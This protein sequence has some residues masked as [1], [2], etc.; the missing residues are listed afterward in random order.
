MRIAE[1]SR[2][3]GVP[4]PTIKYY[5]REG[6]LPAGELTSPNQARYGEEHVR[7][8]RLVRALLELGRL[9]I[10]TI[11][12][13]L[14]EVEGP[15]PD[16][17]NVLGRALVRPPAATTAEDPELAAASR[18]R[19]DDLIASR[20]WLVD[21]AAPAR[22]TV[23]DVLVAFQQLGSP[24][25]EF[26]LE[27]YAEAAERI[28]VTDL[29]FV[30]RRETPAELLHSAVIGTVLGESLL[31]ALRRLA[32]EHESAKTFRGQGELSVGNPNPPDGV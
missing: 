16:I 2:R 14:T 12:E 28:A 5:L 10:A 18:K 25:F 17:H 11:K 1:L 6:L 29:E 32:Q 26:I 19:V 13:I 31:A 22:R 8:L 4:V 7:R 23:A 21:P 24:D 30:K 15:D 27:R 3:T 20:G 9:P